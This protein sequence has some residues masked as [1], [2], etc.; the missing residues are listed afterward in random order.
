MP[1]ALRNADHHDPRGGALAA[2]GERF[3]Q[4]FSHQ[5][6]QDQLLQAHAQGMGK[7]PPAQAPDGA[8]R[9]LQQPDAVRNDPHFCVDRPSCE[10]GHAAG[11]CHLVMDAFLER[12]RQPGGRD[13][14]GFLEIRPVQ[15]IGLVDQGNGRELAPFQGAFQ[16]V[17]PSGNEGLD[18]QAQRLGVPVGPGLGWPAPGSLLETALRDH[19]HGS[20]R[21][22]L[23]RANHLGRSCC[24]NAQA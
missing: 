6:T 3:C 13:V 12:P 2:K 11:T 21:G 19:R 17:L 8:G 10:P 24:L 1:A 22:S 15:G 23:G 9:D 4:Q 16:R 18:N 5:R 7:H 20:R 14:N